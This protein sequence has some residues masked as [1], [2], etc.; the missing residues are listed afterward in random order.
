RPHEW[1][2][3]E[4]EGASRLVLSAFADSLVALLLRKL[5]E[6]DDREVQ[7]A[8]GSDRL[9]GGALALDEGRPEHVVAPHDLVESSPKDVDVEGTA[10]P[11]GDLHRV[12][13][14]LR[15][16]L[17]EHPQT[18]LGERQRRLVALLLQHLREQHATL[19]G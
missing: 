3:A 17:T 4:G 1:A 11:E 8:C 16:E 13:G 14:A 18:L 19:L 10:Q 2:L 5:F 6:V 12:G 7:R 15:L 9:D